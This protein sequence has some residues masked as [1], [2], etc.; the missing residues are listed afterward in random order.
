[1]RIIMLIDMDSFFV[2]CEEL[3]RPEIRGKPVIVGAD[4]KGGSGRGVVSTASYEARKYGIRSGMP[5]S[6]AYRL[7]KDAIFLPVDEPY[8]ESVSEKVMAV[9]RGFSEKFE[10]VS[11]DE[12]YIDVS[13]KI[14]DYDSAMA[15]AKSIKERMLKETGLRCSIGIGPNKLIAKMACEASKPD[16]I[17]LVKEDE[18][19]KFLA[20]M[21][22]E[23]LYGVGK[24][25]AEK[26][27]ALGFK[28][29]SDI[30][31]ANPIILFE[32]FGS[33]GAELSRSANG[34]DNSE[35]ISNYPVKS[36]GRERTFEQDTADPL[37]IK[38]A[39]RQMSDEVASELKKQGFSFKTVTLKIRYSSFDEHLKSR[40]LGYV[41]N[42][43][44]TI[45][46]TALGIYNSIT[47]EEL[48]RKIGVRVSSLE[49]YKGQRK[50]QDY[51]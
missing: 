26:L 41:S 35:V 23:K 20:D 48:I 47:H 25:S 45:Y 9:I 28:K 6:A 24:K 2:A 42:S 1:M 4:P 34:I 43:A 10:Q 5:I 16:G 32:N 3:R 19:K 40:T 49:K 21:P 29:I 13:E 51:F 30:A 38:N 18:A 36:I 31:N 12:A 27:K 22:I 46:N 8:Y 39:L 44:D 15:Y 17:K 50:M 11:I 33:F 7:K 14:K 37:T